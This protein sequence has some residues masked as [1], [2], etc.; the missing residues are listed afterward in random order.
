VVKAKGSKFKT[1]VVGH[2]GIFEA[3]SGYL[4]TSLSR[5]VDKSELVLPQKAET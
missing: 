4:I 3:S 2:G 5:Q 1:A